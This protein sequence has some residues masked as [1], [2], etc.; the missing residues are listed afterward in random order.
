MWSVDRCIFSYFLPPPPLTDDSMQPKIARVEK[1]CIILA[2]IL[3]FILYPKHRLHPSTWADIN[4]LKSMQPSTISILL[5]SLFFDDNRR[6]LCAVHAVRT[7]HTTNCF[8]TIIVEYFALFSADMSHNTAS[9]LSLGS[10]RSTVEDLLQELPLWPSR[11]GI[12]RMSRRPSANISTRLRQ[13]RRSVSVIRSTACISVV[14]IRRVKTFRCNRFA[15][16]YWRKCLR[17]RIT[18]SI[19][20]YYREHESRLSYGLLLYLCCIAI[21]SLWN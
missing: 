21:V 18:H 12:P 19:N 11:Y 4:P 13:E 14:Y 6:I 10:K 15:V 16:F 1:Q 17:A 9:P 2:S 3:S 8:S 20:L 5:V 7:C